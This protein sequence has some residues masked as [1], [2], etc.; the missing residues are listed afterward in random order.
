MIGA[1]TGFANIEKEPKIINNAKSKY[2]Q[3]SEKRK[4]EIN[5]IKNEKTWLSQVTATA[6]CANKGE[7]IQTKMDARKGG[8]IRPLLLM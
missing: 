5:I 4:T 6:C 8:E 1:K 2:V 7:N 3:I